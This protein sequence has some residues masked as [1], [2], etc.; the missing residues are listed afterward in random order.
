M[1]TAACILSFSAILG[2]TVKFIFLFFNIYEKADCKSNK[3][4]AEC[5]MHL[6]A[7]GE[8][9]PS[10]LLLFDQLGK[11]PRSKV[12]AIGK[13]IRSSVVK[14]INTQERFR[15][16]HLSIK[17]HSTIFISHHGPFLFLLFP[18]CQTFPFT[19]SVPCFFPLLLFPSCTISSSPTCLPSPSWC[20]VA[21]MFVLFG[22]LHLFLLLLLLFTRTSISGCC[23][24]EGAI[25]RE[26]QSSQP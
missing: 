9:D 8:L 19:P 17:Q 25:K 1:C 7:E 14:S 5:H 6:V 20:K 16:L 11:S 26:T 22:F 18:Q 21:S 24:S 10:F 4:K 3:R 12:K 13:R 15:T 23:E 2:K